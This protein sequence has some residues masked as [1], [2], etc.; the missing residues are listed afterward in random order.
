MQLFLGERSESHVAVDDASVGSQGGA[1]GTTVE[2]TSKV[3]ASN[4]QVLS[5]AAVGGLRLGDLV[6]VGRSE[7]VHH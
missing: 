5:C 1:V 3:A 6:G 7:H 2:L 4:Q